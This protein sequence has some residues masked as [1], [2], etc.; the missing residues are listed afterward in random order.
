MIGEQCVTKKTQCWTP[1][2]HGPAIYEIR[3][4]GRLDDKWSDQIGGLQITQSIGPDGPAETILVGR[5]ADQAALA[6]VMNT[7]YELHLPVVSVKCVDKE[8]RDGG[9][10]TTA[11]S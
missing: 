4:R 5:L 2:M 6:G 8:G 1:T 11:P 7:L 10:R 9:N 3:V